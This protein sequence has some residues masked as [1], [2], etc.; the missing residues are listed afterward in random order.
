MLAK[1]EIPCDKGL[2]NTISLLKE[3]YLFI[4]NRVEGYHSDIFKTHILGKKVICISGKEAVKLF[5]NANLFKRKDATPKRIQKTLFGV[6]A[7]QSMDD[8]EH[9]HRKSLFMSLTAPEFQKTLTQLMVKEWQDSISKW[10]KAKRVVLFDET[11][12]ILCKIAC[13]WVGIKIPKS[14]IK[15]KANDF[16]AMVDAF[17][18]IG[19]RYWKGRRARIRNEKWIK[20]IIDDIRTD[21]LRVEKNSILYNVAF[22]R[23]FDG[24]LLNSKMAAIELINLIRPIV[25][26]STFITFSALALYDYPIYINKLR[27]NDSNYL[28]MFVQE[29]RR[30]Y[31]FTPFLGGLVKKNFSW[32][33][34]QFKKGTLVLLDIYGMN[35]DSRIWDNPDTFYPEHFNNWNGDLFDFIPQG[36]GDPKNSHRCPGENITIEIMKVSL[37]FLLNKIQYEV[38]N[39]DLSYSLAKMPTLPKSG[40]II[41]N[42]KSIY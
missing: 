36:G 30:Y 25:A 26:I 33:Q 16:S 38:P 6:N 31:P 5:Y 9:I 32:K 23:E 11:K 29:V 14:Q 15:D 13:H 21:K 28:H 4:K 41:N 27:T 12:E 42:I 40:F 8:K 2:D 37:D 34:C 24:K 10:Q 3:G 18:A 20:K 35:H 7:V 19:P 17:G 1:N 22:Y 39:Q